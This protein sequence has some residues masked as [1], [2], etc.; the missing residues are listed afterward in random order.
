MKTSHRWKVYWLVSVAFVSFRKLQK[1][2]DLELLTISESVYR[3]HRHHLGWKHGLAK[4]WN[5]HIHPLCFISQGGN[6]PEKYS[7]Q[8]RWRWGW[9]GMV[10]I[11]SPYFLSLK[12]LRIGRFDKAEIYYTL[13]PPRFKIILDWPNRVTLE[14]KCKMGTMPCF[15][16][17]GASN[18]L[19][20]TSAERWQGLL[21][22]RSYTARACSSPQKNSYH[23]E[24]VI[25]VFIKIRKIQLQ[26]IQSSFN[27]L[28]NR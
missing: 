21:F 24:F 28:A 10:K 27:M 19:Q 26:W 8:G 5:D 2:K 9:G 14:S 15:Q 1:V 25:L 17:H 4:Y 20:F 11:H 7:Q 6:K 12:Q 13:S 18:L 23:G 16:E 22:S 3:T